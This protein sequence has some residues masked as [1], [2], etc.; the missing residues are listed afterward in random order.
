MPESY[1][2]L[3]Q[4]NEHFVE[5]ALRNDPD[6]FTG[7]AKGQN[8]R[9]MWIGCSDSRV[10]A[11]RITG[12]KAGEIFVTRN[13]ANMVVHTDVSMLSVLDFAVNHLKVRHIIVCGHYGCGG[14]KAALS[15]QQ[16]GLL[17]NWLR[18]IK[19]VIRLH[20]DELTA[21]EDPVERERRL[22]EI[23]VI[24]QAHNLCKTSI[25]QNSWRKSEFPHVHGWVYS[26][27]DGR[28]RTLGMDFK[29]IENN[30]PV[31]IY[32]LHEDGHQEP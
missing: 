6:I 2:E 24:E 20:H 18:N 32:K 3:L 26:V 30:N 1:K 4:G 10:P 27:A 5:H 19:D 9:F 15:K 28:I 13:I 12:T 17:D 25:V 16:Y 21:L 11:D 29:A 31:S 8:P 22:T 7:G 14:I 23:N